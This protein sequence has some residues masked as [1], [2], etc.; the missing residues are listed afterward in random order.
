[1]MQADFSLKGLA[2]GPLN[3]VSKKS[4]ASLSIM[5]FCEQRIYGKMKQWNKYCIVRYLPSSHRWLGTPESS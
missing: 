2:F 5:N 3:P 1:M 4:S